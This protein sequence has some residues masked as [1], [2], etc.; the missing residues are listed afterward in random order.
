MPLAWR[1]AS[2]VDLVE[3]LLVHLGIR[4]VALACH[5]MGAIYLFNVL[6][7]LRHVLHPVRPLV[8]FM[9]E[10]FLVYRS[11]SEED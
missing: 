11:A 6:L 9:S 8:C 3:E 7:R 10:F 5:S 2:Y 1:I 4:H